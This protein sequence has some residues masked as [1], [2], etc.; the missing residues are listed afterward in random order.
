VNEVY[1]HLVPRLKMSGSL[2][3]PP[4][5]ICLYGVDREN[6]PF[7]LNSDVVRW[8]RIA[9]GGHCEAFRS[10]DADARI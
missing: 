1:F 2:H 3:P 9:I 8:G 5:P 6:L 7:F 10:V 4:P